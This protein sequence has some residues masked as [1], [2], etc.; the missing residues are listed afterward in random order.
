MPDGSPRPQADIDADLAMVQVIGRLFFVSGM[1]AVAYLGGWLASIM[2]YWQVFALALV[3][4]VISIVG[5]L[6]V[7]IDGPIGEAVRTTDWRILGG[8]LA[9]GAFVLAIGVLRVPLAQEMTF[10]ISLGVI[11]W[12]LTQVTADIAPETRKRIF[13]AAL[14]IFFFRAFPTVGDGYRWFL[15]DRHGFD[16]RFFGQLE[17]IGMLLTLLTGWLLAGLLTRGNIPNILL[18]LTGVATVFALPSLLLVHDGALRAVESATGLGARSLAVIDSAAQSPI[19]N[20]AMIPMLTL[21]AIHAPAKSRAVWFALMGSFM[22]VALTAGDLMT[23]YMNMIFVVE[24][25]N[26]AALPALTVWVVIIATVIPVVTILT[27]RRHVS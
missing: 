11:T 22:N 21:I 13:Y 9:F 16:E 15:I 14:I 7:R 12:M 4:P 24:R 26:Y 23:K 17:T 20:L 10:L 6:L 27:W 18:A 25:G 5:A 1:L 8:G 3:V 2:P 19:M